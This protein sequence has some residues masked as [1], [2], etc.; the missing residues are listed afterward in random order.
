MKEAGESPF[1]CS[2]MY[3]FGKFETFKK[4][5]EEVRIIN[6]KSVISKLVHILTIILM[7]TCL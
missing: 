4:R 3:V 2:E 6:I 5:V 7:I 1:E